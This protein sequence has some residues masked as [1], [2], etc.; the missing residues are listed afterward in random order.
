MK[1]FLLRLIAITFFCVASLTF[2]SETSAC[3]SVDRFISKNEFMP[4]GKQVN[5]STTSEQGTSYKYE[6][7]L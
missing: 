5:N 3:R 6:A 2:K 1:F 7:F 4:A